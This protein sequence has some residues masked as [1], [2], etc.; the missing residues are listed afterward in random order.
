MAN[1]IPLD[2]WSGAEATR[3][4]QE[5]VERFRVSSDKSAKR[6]IWLTWTIAILTFVM[7]GA[8]V[9]QVLLALR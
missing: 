5:A 6:M 7:L 4:L 9:V 1:G 8:V 2:R 3:E